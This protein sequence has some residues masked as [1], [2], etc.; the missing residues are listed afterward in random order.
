MLGVK[1][2]AQTVH[3]LQFGPQLEV[4]QIEIA[5]HAN[6]Q[7]GV[8]ALELDNVI[9]LT[10][11]V[12]HGIDASHHIR[13]VIVETRSGRYQ[14]E[15]TR[16]IGRLQLLPLLCG[17]PVGIGHAEVMKGEMPGAEEQGSAMRS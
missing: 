13:P 4:R 8:C 12:E 16:H 1:A 3:K 11:Q 15:G 14:V 6:L 7:K 2:V 10:R 17:L 5:P 9:V